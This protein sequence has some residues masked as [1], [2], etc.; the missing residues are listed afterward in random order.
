MKALKTILLCTALM[1]M[2]CENLGDNSD[3]TDDDAE[4]TQLKGVALLASSLTT[5]LGLDKDLDISDGTT[6]LLEKYKN[7]FGGLEGL[8][9]GKTFADTTG[10]SNKMTGYFL[11]LGHLASNAA[12]ICNS[13]QEANC[14]CDSP[15]AARD[16]LERAIPYIDF[17]TG[18]NR[19]LVNQ[20]AEICQESQV[21]AITSLLA[22]VAFAK[23][24]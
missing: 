15:S 1:F 4:S 23:R 9:V 6:S 3:A 20:F 16:M 5:T 8:S 7:N 22:S 13:T 12:A 17:G 21:E 14:L 24:N 2:A 11:S 18:E 10:G 19:E